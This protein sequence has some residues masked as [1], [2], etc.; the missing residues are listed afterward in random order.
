MTTEEL[1]EDIESLAGLRRTKTSPEPS[2]KSFLFEYSFEPQESKMRTG[3][4]GVITESLANVQLVD[5]D[6][7]ACLAMFKA[8]ANKAPPDDFDMI[9][10]RPIPSTS[11]REALFR[12]ADSVLAG[13]QRFQAVAIDAFHG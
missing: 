5:L 4:Q 7:N 11:L 1:L 6:S 8:T 10:G 9:P 13:E 2:K 3:S 12:Y